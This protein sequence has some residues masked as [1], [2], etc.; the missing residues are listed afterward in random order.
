MI[1]LWEYMGNKSFYVTKLGLTLYNFQ[2]LNYFYYFNLN[3]NPIFLSK[4]CVHLH[5]I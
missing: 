5:S 4:G 2:H 3:R 1:E